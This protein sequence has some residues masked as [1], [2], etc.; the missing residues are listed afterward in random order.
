MLDTLHQSQ[1]F[2]LASP[3]P[4]KGKGPNFI[5]IY[6]YLI[7]RKGIELGVVRCT[8]NH[9]L[10]IVGPQTLALFLLP[11]PGIFKVASSLEKNFGSKMFNRHLPV[12]KEP[13]DTFIRLCFS[14]WLFIGAFPFTH[15]NGPFEKPVPLLVDTFVGFS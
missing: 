10:R 13:R 8:F 6:I 3:P 9:C 5:Y 1:S 12:L 7:G 14:E 4:K 15:S 2:A 11:C